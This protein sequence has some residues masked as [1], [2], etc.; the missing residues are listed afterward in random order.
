[1]TENKATV[2]EMAAETFELGEVQ[3][4]FADLLWEN[5]PLAT[6][7]LVKLCAE[8]FG[9]K[10]STTYTVLH[11]LCERGL[12]IN[13]NGVVRPLITRAGFYSAKSVRFV[14]ETFGGSLPSFLAAF[15]ANGE[16]SQSEVEELQK[17]IDNYKKGN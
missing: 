16:L 7:E 6:G 15:A 14:R 2:N 5:S 1:M 11:K 8:R 10:K 12:F 17:L 13:E 3:S 4:R 9:W